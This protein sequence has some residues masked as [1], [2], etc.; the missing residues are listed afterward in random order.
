MT[1]RP[2]H[3]D[4][5]V[6]VVGNKV[7][8]MKKAAQALPNGQY[9]MTSHKMVPYDVN[10]KAYIPGWRQISF[11]EI[12]CAGTEA[13]A[14]CF[15]VQEGHVE[16]SAD[17]SV[18]CVYS[19]DRCARLVFPLLKDHGSVPGTHV[20]ARWDHAGYASDREAFQ[21]LLRWKYRFGEASGE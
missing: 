12:T 20:V 5:V 15:V 11:R 13:F 7:S 14:I 3:E 6:R 10:K 19:S 17:N 8:D 2:R 16:Y 1:K 9:W 4:S 18:S 21:T